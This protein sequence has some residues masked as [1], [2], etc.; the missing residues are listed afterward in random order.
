MTLVT[1]IVSLPCSK[2]RRSSVKKNQPLCF[3]SWLLS[4][5]LSRDEFLLER[6]CLC[7]AWRERTGKEDPE[8]G[9][10]FFFF[11]FGTSFHGFW[12]PI[13]SIIHLLLCFRYLTTTTDLDRTITIG[14]SLRDYRAKIERVFVPTFYTE[15]YHCTVPMLYRYGT[16]WLYFLKILLTIGV[17]LYFL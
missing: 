17:R 13:W 14:N 6:A 1:V 10:R 16:H 15:M 8:F 2:H 7:T 11:K 12:I 4:W 5:T 3:S 9:I